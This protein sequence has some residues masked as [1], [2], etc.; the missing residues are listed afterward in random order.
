VLPKTT[1]DRR[2][3]ALNLLTACDP[4]N[5]VGCLIYIYLY[6][7]ELNTLLTAISGRSPSA[8]EELLESGKSRKAFDQA[9]RHIFAYCSLRFRAILDLMRW[10]HGPV[11]FPKLPLKFDFD[12]EL[13]SSEVCQG[14]VRSPSRLA[15]R[16]GNEPSD[17][18]II[19]P[20]MTRGM[21]IVWLS[22]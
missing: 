16:S 11:L 3:D 12:A 7:A 21:A 6:E 9:R 18:Q 8:Q 13:L 14:T 22:R 15:I 20:P 17:E 2:I 5:L 19:I 1:L 4:T 10:Q